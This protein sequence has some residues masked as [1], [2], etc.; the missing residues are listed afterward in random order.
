MLHGRVYYP[1]PLHTQPA[2]ASLGYRAGQ[3]PEA[4]RA[5]REVLSL[6]VHSQLT[7]M[8]LERTIQAVAAFFGDRRGDD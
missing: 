7:E 4:E 5:C 6:P 3:F 2:C 1:A 8:Q